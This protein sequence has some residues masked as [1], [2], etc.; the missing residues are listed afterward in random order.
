MVRRERHHSLRWT[1]CISSGLLRTTGILMMC[2][3]N[4][5]TYGFSVSLFSHSLSLS[6]SVSLSCSTCC[7]RLLLCSLRSSL[8]S[9]LRHRSK[10]DV[11]FRQWC[12]VQRVI[13]RIQIRF[14]TP[15]LSATQS[16]YTST[17]IPKRSYHQVRMRNVSLILQSCPVHRARS[18]VCHVQ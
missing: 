3:T 4:R 17:T 15:I 12:S 14:A 16:P 7:E 2:T 5:T 6:L 8:C 13:M 1:Q 9:S 10:Q 18:N 11:Q